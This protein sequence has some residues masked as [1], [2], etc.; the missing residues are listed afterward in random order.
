MKEE[1]FT[2]STS[3]EKALGKLLLEEIIKGN[4]CAIYSSPRLWWI[5][6]TSL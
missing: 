1:S 6:M 4:L 3:K 5:V 2:I